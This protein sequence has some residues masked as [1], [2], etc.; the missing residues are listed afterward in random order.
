MRHAW[1]MMA[2]AVAGLPAAL[3]G[4]P[5]FARQN[6]MNCQ[7]CHVAYPKLNTF[8]RQFR[9]RGYTLQAPD[10]FQGPWV[11]QDYFPIA[12]QGMSGYTFEGDNVQ[13][14]LFEIAAFQIFA[15]GQI[16]PNLF[17]YLHHHLVL[18]DGPGEL[19]EAWVRWTLPG[20]PLAIRLGKFE[21]PLANSPGKTLLTHFEP[22]AYEARLGMNPDLL[23]SSKH[24]LE[25]A[26][27]LQGWWTFFLDFVKE[28]GYQSAFARLRRTLGR[29]EMGLLLQ[30]GE[31]EM[32]LPENTP[33][34]LAEGG[35]FTDRYLRGGLDFDLYLSPRW[36]LS[37]VGYY[38]SQSNPHGDGD[39]GAYATGYLEL[40]YVPSFSWLAG[41]RLEAFRNLRPEEPA[42]ALQHVGG[43]ASGFPDEGYWVNGYMQFYIAPNVKLLAEYLYDVR[44][45]PA[46]KGIVGMH[47]A[48]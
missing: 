24:G 14:G 46:S 45:Q 21:L 32:E 10:A 35:H 18:N 34:L 38:G 43:E 25:V 15:G 42:P 17:T 29:G 2:S 31:A 41:V 36:L 9:D 23:V 3:E 6:G 12:L 20:L 13:E 11:W 33:A 39:P 26:W 1:W 44:N 8:G 4:L 19:H 22:R 28:G 47:Y 7:S 16:A 5:A 37:G 30:A 27:N 48:F 40:T